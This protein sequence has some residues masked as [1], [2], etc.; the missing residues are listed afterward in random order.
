VNHM[1]IMADAQ[2]ALAAQ[3]NIGH[4]ITIFRT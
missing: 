1:S 4:G 3:S 2:L